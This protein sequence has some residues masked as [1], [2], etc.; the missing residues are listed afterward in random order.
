MARS[1]PTTAKRNVCASKRPPPTPGVDGVEHTVP[2]PPDYAQ[3]WAVM[4]PATPANY[5][6]IRVANHF[7]FFFLCKYYNYNKLYNYN[8]NYNKKPSSQLICEQMQIQ[9]RKTW[10]NN[11]NEIQIRRNSATSQRRIADWRMWASLIELL[12]R[13]DRTGLEKETPCQVVRSTQD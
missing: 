8:N 3:T 4:G 1:Y 11:R 12:R 9:A 6:V 2:V 10:K 13:Q 5:V 7:F